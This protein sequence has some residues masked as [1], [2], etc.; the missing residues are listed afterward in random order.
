[1]REFCARSGTVCKFSYSVGYGTAGTANCPDYG[2]KKE[3]IVGRA[4]ALSDSFL[5]NIRAPSETLI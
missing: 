2:G 5:R 3:K 4:A 1:V